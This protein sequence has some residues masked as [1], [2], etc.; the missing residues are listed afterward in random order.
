MPYYILLLKA[1]NVS[2]FTY[3]EFTETSYLGLTFLMT[4]IL[5]PAVV[6]FPIAL[7]LVGSGLAILAMYWQRLQR[8]ADCAMWLI[9]LGWLSIAAAILT[10]LLSQSGLPPD[11]PYRGLLN[12]H[13]S[14]AVGATIVY[15]A[16]L[17][18]WWL[19]RPRAGKAEQRPLLHDSASR[20]WAT[21]LLI[22]GMT[23]VALSGWFGGEL[24]Y[25]WGVNVG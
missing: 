15:A 7:L 24:V 9:L 17:Y 13:I 5:H 21:A 8:A 3:L 14:T 1:F 12:R 20:W 18:L 23:L 19:R 4:S 6:H 22:A 25:E 11:A 16:V 2:N 10:G